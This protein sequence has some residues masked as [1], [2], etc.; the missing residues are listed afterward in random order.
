MC[1]SSIIF[2]EN[3][4]S[5]ITGSA[6]FGKTLHFWKTAPNGSIV[7]SPYGVNGGGAWES[8]PPTVL[9][10]RHAGFEVQEAHQ[11]PVHPPLCASMTWLILPEGCGLRHPP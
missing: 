4:H 10:A 6:R 9:F 7:V 2:P 1:R 5:S 3:E 11:V 8:N